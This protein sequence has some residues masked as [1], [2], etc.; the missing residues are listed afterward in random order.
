IAGS[1][2]DL[3]GRVVCRCGAR[4]VVK[5]IRD[6]WFLAYS[7]EGWK[8]RAHEALSSMRV[9]PEEAREWFK[10]T[11]DWLVDKACVRGSGIGTPLPWQ[12][13]LIIETLSDSTI[14]MCYYLVAKF[15]NSG[16][17]KTSQLTNE[18]FDYVLLG[19]GS[20]KEVS[21]RTGASER[22]LRAMREEFL[23]WYPVDL[24]VSAKELIPNHL[25]FAIFHHTAIFPKEDWPRMFAVN[26]MVNIEGR[27]M[28][29]S[30]GNFVPIRDAIERYGSDATRC[31]LL[32]SAEDMNDPNWRAKDV[33]STMVNLA[34][35]Y[36][37][38]RRIVSMKGKGKEG[39]VESWL[40]TAFQRGIRIV[41]ENLD[42][43][44]TR[45]ALENAFYELFADVR[46]YLEIREAGASAPLLRRGLDIWTRLM[47]PFAP[48][49]C[50]EIWHLMGRS[51]F[52]ALAEWPVY[53]ET[54]VDIGSELLMEIVEGVIGDSQ[55][56]IRAL[57]AIEP[58]SVCY[59]TA[60]RWKWTV[61]LRALELAKI[62][63]L[64]MRDLMAGLREDEEIRCRIKE[65]ARYSQ[66][67]VEKLRT[68][69]R[70]EMDRRLKAG[71]LDE[72]GALREIRPYLERRMRARVL[73]YGEDDPDR[74]DP[75][76]RAKLAEPYRP[77]IYL[78]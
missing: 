3:T 39:W 15:V 52:V 1:M 67:L 46:R 49:L 6:Q 58:K 22:T 57:R 11:I 2:Y 38:A 18:L 76:G 42:R 35:F 27:K 20:A 74:Y 5:V 43:L 53:D 34:R 65:A 30:K 41:T 44:K 50:E 71:V 31:A 19:I 59:Y 29:K 36:D 28:S 9:C 37:L 10:A 33:Q 77:A 63:R 56:I 17:V 61:Y 48:H 73:V 47:A 40:E 72:R 7:D 13:D 16:L 14:Y 8:R 26:G 75:M 78:E 4:C 45:T 54:C 25:T 55:N 68:L 60:S 23:Y 62:G 32:L 69:P 70:D 64:S 66:G 51:G 21:E 12:P 24:R